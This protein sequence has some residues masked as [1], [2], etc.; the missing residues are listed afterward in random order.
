MKSRSLNNL[1]V[2]NPMIGLKAKKYIK[3]IIGGPGRVFWVV[4]GVVW[5]V[6]GVVFLAPVPAVAL[7]LLLP[8][9]KPPP[10]PP[11]PPPGQFS[12]W[13]KFYTIYFWTGTLIKG[14]DYNRRSRL[15]VRD[16]EHFVQASR[17]KAV[18]LLELRFC[19]PSCMQAVWLSKW[20]SND[21]LVTF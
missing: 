14:R 8:V 5:V 17:L 2:A 16:A 10:G 9:L 11:K 4:L 21:F 20:L 7:P 18:Q 3:R 15:C 6:M 1:L 19:Q 13:G 12:S